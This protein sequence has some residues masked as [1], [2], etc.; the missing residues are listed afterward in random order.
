MLLKF[1]KPLFNKS[2][3]LHITFQVNVSVRKEK[4]KGAL[5]HHFFKLVFR[6]SL[7]VK[8]AAQFKNSLRSCKNKKQNL[9]GKQRVCATNPQNLLRDF[10][11]QAT[12]LSRQ[13]PK[14]CFGLPAWKEIFLRP[15][16][17]LRSI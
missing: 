8:I 2:A 15:F 10:G 9:E 7:V 1:F 12:G 11:R 5:T 6:A 16:L 14:L 13:T 4:S 3:H 17:S